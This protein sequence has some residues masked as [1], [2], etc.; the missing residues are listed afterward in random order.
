MDNRKLSQK[1][2]KNVASKIGGRTVV[3][4]G[5]LWSAKADARSDRFLVECKTTRLTYFSIRQTVWEKIYKEALKDGMRIPILVVWL[6]AES[7]Y[8]RKYLVVSMNSLD[9]GDRPTSP[10]YD[11][12]VSFNLK[13]NGHPAFRVNLDSYSLAIFEYT[14]DNLEEILRKLK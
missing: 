11:T 8:V 10:V 9:I 3:G 13:F 4:S 2:E 6:S 12:G 5:C 7:Y 1:Q 14:D